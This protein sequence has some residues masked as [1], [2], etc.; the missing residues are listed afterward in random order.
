MKVA[1]MIQDVPTAKAIPGVTAT[2]RSLATGEALAS[3]ISD[4][5]GMVEFQ[6]NG[7][8][9][10]C[11]VQITKAGETRL[12]SSQPTGPAGAFDVSEMQRVLQA[13]GGATGG[14]SAVEGSGLEVTTTGAAN[15]SVSVGTGTAI[16]PDG[17]LFVAY[18]PT[19]LTVPA[20]TSPATSATFFVVVDG[21]TTASSLGQTQ[22]KVVESVGS[23]Q[24]KLAEVV[25]R[26]GSEVV[27]AADIQTGTR[28]LLLQGIQTTQ[29]VITATTAQTTPTLLSAGNAPSR[30]MHSYVTLPAGTWDVTVSVLASTN[31]EI[32]INAQWSQFDNPGSGAAMRSGP[33]VS[34]VSHVV[35]SNGNAGGSTWQASAWVTAAGSAGEYTLTRQSLS[36]NAIV[37]L[38]Y[39]QDVAV[40][41]SYFYVTN[42]DDH[43]VQVWTVG[44][45]YVSKFGVNG[46]ANGQFRFPKGI[47]LSGSSVW[48][49]DSGNDRVQRLTASGS[50]LSFTSKFGTSGT[51]SGDFASPSG[52]AYGGG[53][54]YVTDISRHRVLRFNTSGVFQNEWG[55]FGTAT[56][57]FSSPY[58]VAVDGSGNVLVADSGNDRISKFT[59][60]GTFISSFAT[61]NPLNVE[62]DAAGNIWVTSSADDA[63]RVY[64]SGGALLAA[65]TWASF[66][67]GMAVSGAQMIV[68][69]GSTT[70]VADGGALG[71]YALTGSYEVTSATL[72]V[73]AVPRR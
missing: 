73:T 45:S 62:V 56:S 40:G 31:G 5:D 38:N 12:L 72:S 54:L 25:S 66:P 33:G 48:V 59:S 26:S 34:Q 46:T 32:G 43:H 15:R 61:S 37:P 29:G 28:P 6:L 1:L 64:S 39:P 9:P 11:Q 35:A 24:T 16:T 52:I 42:Q 47:A 50:T 70:G 65:A 21:S 67:N 4:D 22:L 27:A 23:G 20:P 2:L 36:T 3:G 30:L 19:V 14:V 8:P 13:I 7:T 69:N 51:G 53:F 57:Q 55:G 44:K 63:V 17:F 41:T 60:T 58:G 18:A 71:F 10:P 68:V 49:V